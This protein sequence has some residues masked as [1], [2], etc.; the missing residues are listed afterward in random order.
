MISSLCEVEHLSSVGW[1]RKLTN[2]YY[3]CKTHSVHLTF[4]NYQTQEGYSCVM[5]RWQK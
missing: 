1:N 3:C 5:E 2:A 4:T